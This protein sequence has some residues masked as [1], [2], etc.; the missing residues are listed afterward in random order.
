MLR[1]LARCKL[2]KFV[3]SVIWQFVR[4]LFEICMLRYLARRK[5]LE[6]VRSKCPFFII[7]RRSLQI[8]TRRTPYGDGF[9]RSVTDLMPARKPLDIL[10]ILCQSTG[11]T[12]WHFSFYSLNSDDFNGFFLYTSM[13]DLPSLTAAAMQRS[14]VCESELKMY[15]TKA[16]EK[17]KHSAC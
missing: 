3:Y 2:F 15:R 9:L 12:V 11:S 14:L 7:C 16:T 1:Y 10:K 17:I 5:L 8:R 4:K 6:C 13:W